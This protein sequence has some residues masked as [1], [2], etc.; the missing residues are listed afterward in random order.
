MVES[1]Q[2]DTSTLP[3]PNI[4]RFALMVLSDCF[5]FELTK[6]M[7]AVGLWQHVRAICHE[8]LPAFIL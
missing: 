2:L 8:Y 3:H 4:L 7:K 6:A 5:W 1:W